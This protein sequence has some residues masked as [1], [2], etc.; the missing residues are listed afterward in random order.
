MMRNDP[1][2]PV[3]VN[4]QVEFDIHHILY[5]ATDALL[6]PQLPDLKQRCHVQVSSVNHG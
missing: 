1:G 4:L 6:L 5:A 2:T 3:E